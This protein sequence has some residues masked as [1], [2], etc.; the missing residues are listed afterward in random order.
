MRFGQKFSAAQY[1][2]NPLV[3]HHIPAQQLPQG[4]FGSMDMPRY[5]V[6][7]RNQKPSFEEHY[8]CR[9]PSQNGCLWMQ[10]RLHRYSLERHLVR[11]QKGC[12][13]EP[14]IIARLSHHSKPLS[15]KTSDVEFQQNFEHA[16]SHLLCPKLFAFI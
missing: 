12:Y 11:I 6:S 4:N 2:Q 14:L 8:S 3:S 15:L 16:A 9:G 1:H 7:S 13:H 5:K 10:N